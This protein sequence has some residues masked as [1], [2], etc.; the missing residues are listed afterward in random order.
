MER[1]VKLTPAR[2]NAV[3]GREGM[4]ILVQ[5]NEPEKEE[6]DALGCLGVG[7][8]AGVPGC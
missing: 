4:K 2:D 1:E 8:D 3:N 5:A 7:A 6:S